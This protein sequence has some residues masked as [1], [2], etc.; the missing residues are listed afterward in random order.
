M[1]RDK[2]SIVVVC[3]PNTTEDL[4]IAMKRIKEIKENKI[5]KETEKFLTS[6]EEEKISTYSNSSTSK[7]D[8]LWNVVAKLT[9]DYSEDKVNG[10]DAVLLKS[11]GLS[12]TTPSTAHVD[13][14][15]LTYGCSGFTENGSKS[16]SR[17]KEYG[18]ISASSR[19]NDTIT[20]PSSW[21]Y[22]YIEDVFTTV[23]ANI[24]VNITK[25]SSGSTTSSTKLKITNN[26]YE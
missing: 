24:T 17:N 3:V 4:S 7:E 2:S 13:S 6:F 11:V 14:V 20:C 21:D 25:R 8:S 10:K 26:I 12:I 16:Q 15:S 9:I 1:D 5:T 18:K 22:V 19:L 23:G